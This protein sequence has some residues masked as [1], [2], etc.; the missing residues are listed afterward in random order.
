MHA[1]MVTWALACVRAHMWAVVKQEISNRVV[2]NSIPSKA[3]MFW[4]TMAS[5]TMRTRAHNSSVEQLEQL[6][7]LRTT[8][9]RSTAQH[10]TS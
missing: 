9:T 8:D 4:L 10:S 3:R 1:C 7:R 2:L 6:A 5:L